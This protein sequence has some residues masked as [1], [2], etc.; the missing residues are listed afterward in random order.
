MGI[1]RLTAAVCR[2]CCNEFDMLM[3]ALGWSLGGT[4]AVQRVEAVRIGWRDR[5]FFGSNEA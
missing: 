1:S 2:L 3:V 4:I 5:A